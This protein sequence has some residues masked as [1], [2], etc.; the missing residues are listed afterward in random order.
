MVFVISL[1]F[2][3]PLRK[4]WIAFTFIEKIKIANNFLDYI[5]VFLKKKATVLPKSNNLNQQAIKHQ[6][7]Q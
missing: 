4:A 1:S 7:D 3:Y 2:I 5:D 6:K